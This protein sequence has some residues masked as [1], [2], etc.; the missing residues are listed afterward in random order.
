VV[1]R[2][3]RR[4]PLRAA[5]LA[6]L[7]SGFALPVANAG[8]AD[9]TRGYELVSTEHQGYPTGAGPAPNTPNQSAWLAPSGDWVAYASFDSFV[10]TSGQPGTYRG[11]RGTGGWSNVGLF[12]VATEAMLLRTLNTMAVSDD[13]DQILLTTSAQLLPAD[14]DTES[15]LYLNDVATG[16]ALVTPGTP[17][18]VTYEGR[19]G[20]MS[21]ILFLTRSN[22][23][24]LASGTAP[25]LYEWV[26]G[27]IRLAGIKPDGTADPN[28]SVLGRHE[29]PS[30]P[31]LPVNAVTV[32]ARSIVF[33]SPAPSLATGGDPTRIY[34]RVDGRTTLH[35]SASRCTRGDCNAASNAVFAGTSRDG[36]TVFMITAQQLTDD[37][38][39]TRLDLFAFDANS[40]SL[41]R[42]TPTLGVP[43]I[44]PGSGPVLGSSVDGQRVYIRTIGNR[45]AVWDHGVL[46][47]I[48]TANGSVV[49][50]D[51]NC[52][53]ADGRGIAQTNPDGDV[54][55]FSTAAFTPATPG[56][57]SGA[58]VYHWRTSTATLTKLAG[59]GTLPNAIFATIDIDCG[60]RTGITEDGNE[61][62]FMT[63]DALD[64]QDVNAQTD[65][66]AW[67]NGQ[68]SLVSTGTEAYPST[69]L[70]VSADGRDV[71]FTS[72]LPLAPQDQDVVQDV[73]DARVGGGFPVAP[74]PPECAGEGCRG[75]MSSPPSL[76]R[77]GSNTLTG[78]GNL[79]V[80]EV[81]LNV[82]I[83]AGRARRRLAARGKFAVVVRV[84]EDV[85]VGVR[86]T[87]RIRGRRRTVASFSGSVDAGRQRIVLSLSNAA[88]RKLADTGRLQVSV[89]VRHS[90]ASPGKRL[91]A[92]LSR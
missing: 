79:R 20:D 88:R 38:T 58:G 30:T 41:T 74:P 34:V 27:V 47:N 3:L 78:P 90:N 7:S 35:A 86:A 10:G 22:L 85:D 32:D 70:G 51:S 31:A 81:R 83:V 55:A 59:E 46:T 9:G 12:P 65:V 48:G 73:Y 45:L 13:A 39:D 60:L 84:S 25:K 49:G 53:Q 43:A 44:A 6:L 80:G 15:D 5:A 28:G 57:P 66:Y 69:L 19:S 14:T 63:S 77:A 29:D 17:A 64:R 42:L 23:V 18:G 56:N 33:T 71:F 87:A 8:A 54:L 37:D 21:H 76:P 40:L 24:P 91:T 4:W 16:L 52:T 61:V 92:T 11:T 75:P 62:F 72:T 26:N 89:V 67:Q 68:T 2:T 1:K 36:S 82:N 50:G